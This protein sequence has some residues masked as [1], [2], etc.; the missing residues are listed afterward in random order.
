MKKLIGYT[1]GLIALYLIVAHG[2]NFKTAAGGAT[3]FVTGTVK[4]LQGR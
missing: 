2:A 3:S 4:T 1:G